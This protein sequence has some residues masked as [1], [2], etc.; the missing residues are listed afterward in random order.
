MRHAMPW[1]IPVLVATAATASIGEELDRIPTPRPDGWI[2]DLT[3]QIAPKTITTLNALGDSVSGREG[4]ELAV[5]VIQSTDGR[6]PRRFA[7]ELFN[8]WGIGRREEDD[9]VLLLVAL[10]DRKAEIVLGDGVD[11]PDRVRT[12]QRI[13]DETMLPFFRRGDPDQA[14][15][16]GARRC[17]V[18]ILGADLDGPDRAILPLA[19]PPPLPRAAPARPPGVRGDDFPWGGLLGLG[20]GLLGLGGTWVGARR[21]LRFRPRDCPRCKVSMARLGETEDDA[22]LSRSERAEERIRSA[23][24]DVWSCQSCDHVIKLRYGTLFTSYSSCPECKAQ[25]KHSTS[26][27][28]RHATRHRTGLERID[29]RCEHCSYRHSYDRVIPCLPPPSQNSGSSSSFGSSYGFSGGSSSGGGA[30]GGW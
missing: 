2:T 7:T 12:S 18:E 21:Y 29:E 17:A 22:H 11:D 19:A 25:T 9:G 23:D 27:T 20:G 10:R 26:R 3:G 16:Q 28:V 4:P 6:V 1:S 8:R 13:M 30:S 14:I 5:V 24:Y 15:L